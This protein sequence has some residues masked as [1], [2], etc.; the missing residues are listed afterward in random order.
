MHFAAAVIVAFLSP[1]ALPKPHEER[2]GFNCEPD[3]LIYLK[4]DPSILDKIVLSA[5]GREYVLRKTADSPRDT[6]SDTDREVEFD[7][8]IEFKALR[9]ISIIEK[10]VKMS[11]KARS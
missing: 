4:T 5:S 8:D 9:E 1:L 7:G 3:G 2:I 6:F 10:G 11:C